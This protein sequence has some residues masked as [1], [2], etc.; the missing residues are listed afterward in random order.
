VTNFVVFASSFGQDPRWLDHPILGRFTRFCFLTPH[1]KSGVPLHVTS[2]PCS[3][4]THF[5]LPPEDRF[6]FLSSSFPRSCLSPPGG[7]E[8]HVF[9]DPL[10]VRQVCRPLYQRL[11][12]GRAFLF[13][14]RQLSRLLL[15]RRSP[16]SNPPCIQPFAREVRRAFFSEHTSPLPLPVLGRSSL[17]RVRKSAGR[18]FIVPFFPC[19]T[20]RILAYPVNFSFRLPFCIVPLIAP[21]R[22]IYESP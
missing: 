21:S 1:V 2:W 10:V 22:G 8:K 11:T 18:F 20:S 12:E 6:G 3:S 17:C 4:R 7:I 15:G 5:V 16:I 14:P 19:A 9:F 13:I